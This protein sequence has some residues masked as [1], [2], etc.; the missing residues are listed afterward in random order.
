MENTGSEIRFEVGFQLS[1]TPT[2][3]KIFKDLGIP[4]VFAKFYRG[5]LLD[6]RFKVVINNTKSKSTKEGCGSPQG[7]VSSP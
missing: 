1:G 7:T 5:F 2:P 4:P 6:R 3:Y